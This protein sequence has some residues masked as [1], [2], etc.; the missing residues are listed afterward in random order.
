MHPQLAALAARQRG[1]FTTAQALAVG[2]EYDEIQQHLI[3]RRWLR[4]RRGA[5][6]EA[7][8]AAPLDRSAR[9]LLEL[10]A[11]FLTLVRPS[12]VSHVSAAV[13]HGLPL[14]DPDLGVLH[15]TRSELVSSRLEARVRH[16]AAALPSEHCRRRSGFD[17]T[18]RA[19]T[20]L[21]VART[22]DLRAAVV[23]CDAALASG[24][25]QDELQ[26]VLEFCRDWPGSRTAGRA[27][28]LADPGAESP[29]ES[30]ARLVCVEQGLPRPMTQQVVA[31]TRGVIG[32]VDL[33]WKQESTIGEFDGR[34]KY[35]RRPSD[36]PEGDA[37]VLWREK[38]REDR[39][40]EA[41]YEVVRIVWADLH[42]PE[43]LAARVR[44]AFARSARLVDRL[45]GSL[46]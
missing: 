21:D 31:D 18:S 26:H 15:V 8:V 43:Q 3:S 16:H 37:D 12:V 2:Y 4:L 24:V 29:G 10:R 41:G 38:R 17:V 32:R 7:Q 14:L 46:A 30:V 5:Y 1:P 19:R 6:V 42:K 35:D 36:D 20:A 27:V 34:V 22:A 28:E 44:S 11:L 39:L 9:H 13:V 23:A 33:L 40:R 25:P 45:T